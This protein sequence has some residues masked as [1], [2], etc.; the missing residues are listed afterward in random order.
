MESWVAVNLLCTCY[1]CESLSARCQTA[2]GRIRVPQSVYT[3]LTRVSEEVTLQGKRDCRYNIQR[4]RGTRHPCACSKDGAHKSWVKECQ[5]CL[6][7]KHRHQLTASK[8]T[9]PQSY[10]HMILTA[11]NMNGQETDS[12]T[13][14]LKRHTAMPTPKQ[15]IFEI[16]K[17]L[18]EL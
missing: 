8:K 2:T 1:E 14:P 3:L 15:P 16:R 17:R 18:S 9:G 10:H 13:E 4:V 6:E 11:N 12:P 7:T 5:W